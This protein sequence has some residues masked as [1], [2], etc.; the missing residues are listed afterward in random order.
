MSSS[1]E[2]SAE[3]LVFFSDAVVAIAL[4]L[5]ILPLADVV[6]EAA[7]EHTESLKVITENQWKIYSFLLS[8]F[9][10]GRLWMS[11]HR[12]FEQIKSYNRW[13]LNVNLWWLLTIVVLPFPTE[14]IGGF[15]DD[16]FTA[17]FY[18]ATI[19]AADA[20]LMGMVLITRRDPDVARNPGGVPDPQFFMGMFNLGL[21]VLALVLAT[22][23]PGVRYLALLLLLLN[24]PVAWVY[25]RR[26]QNTQA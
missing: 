13:L 7:A 14:M 12:L 16:R 3:R 4:T 20:C 8:F 19:L 15:D 18:I 5:L 11:H 23:V 9:V 10:I 25:R 1:V 2:R 24:L 21:L 17:I 22:F 6:P 26:I